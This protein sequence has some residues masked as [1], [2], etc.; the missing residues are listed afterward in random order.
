V[1]DVFDALTSRRPYKEAWN[2]QDAFDYLLKMAGSAFDRDC[3]DALIGQR[4][5]VERIQEHFMEYPGV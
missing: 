1:A 2:N 4:E 5:E 3:V